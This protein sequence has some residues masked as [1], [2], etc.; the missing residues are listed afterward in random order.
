[1][2]GTREEIRARY[3]ELHG[4]ERTAR[5]ELLGLLGAA[6]LAWKWTEAR[7]E[8]AEELFAAALEDEEARPSWRRES[9]DYKNV[10]PEPR[11]WRG[12]ALRWLKADRL[13]KIRRPAWQASTWR[14]LAR[15]ASASAREAEW[16]ERVAELARTAAKGPRA[17]VR[18]S[19]W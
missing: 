12:R 7:R 5:A 11:T 6:Q 17:P 15:L 10:Q 1:M 3:V 18:T 8:E 16:A 19:A 14:A 4:E 2:K 13:W 9:W